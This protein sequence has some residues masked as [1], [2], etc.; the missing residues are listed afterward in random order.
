[1]AADDPYQSLQ[2][3]RARIDHEPDEL[4]PENDNP[5][6]RFDRL[7]MGTDAV[8]DGPA[9]EGL[10]AES[11]AIIENLWSDTTFNTETRTDEPNPPD[12]ASLPLAWPVND[13][14]EV[15]YRRSLRQDFQTLED[16]KYRHTEHLLIL[17]IGSRAGVSST[18]QGYSRTTNELLSTTTR[19]T[20]SDV[21]VEV[22]VTY[23]RGFETVPYD[24]QNIQIDLINRMIR[25]LRQEQTLAAAA[26]EDYAGVGEDLDSVVDESVRERVL[27]I[28]PPGGATRAL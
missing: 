19:R 22:R 5:E 27:D 3:I 4:F 23:D 18:A 11:R 26:P 25:K 24:V 8:G 15:E 2:R 6:K 12:N 20:W 14:T 9:W 10:E 21:A 7:I 1:M 28:T 17:E 16:W 13:V